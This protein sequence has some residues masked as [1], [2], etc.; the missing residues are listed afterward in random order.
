MDKGRT[1]TKIDEST[2]ATIHQHVKFF[3]DK[4]IVTI[5]D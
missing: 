2:G 3:T 5:P 4:Y 1:Y